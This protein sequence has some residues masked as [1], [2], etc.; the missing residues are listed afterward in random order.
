MF[1]NYHTRCWPGKDYEKRVAQLREVLQRGGF[2]FEG[3]DGFDEA[4]DGEGIA[5]AA[6]TT[7][8][9]ENAAFAG[10]LDGNAH[11]SGDA[12]AVNLGDAVKN[13]DDFPGAGFDDGFESIVKLLGGFADGEAAVDFEHRHGAGFADVD[14]HGQTVSHGRTS[15]YPNVGGDGDSPYRTALYAGG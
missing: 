3:G 5:D 15:I 10:E 7:D 1:G 13:D 12:G 11:Q 4:G 9:A 14:F 8:E 2:G 6:R